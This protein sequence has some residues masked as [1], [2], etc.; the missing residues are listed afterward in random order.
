[1]LLHALLFSVLAPFLINHQAFPNTL[2]R[3]AHLTSLPSVLTSFLNSEAKVGSAISGQ[4]KCN[5]S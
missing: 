4:E 2:A 5:A 1:M 3:F